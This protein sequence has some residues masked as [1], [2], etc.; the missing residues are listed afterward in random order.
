[1]V[2][3]LNTNRMD[4]TWKEVPRME[5]ISREEFF[6]KFVRQRRPLVIRNLMDSWKALAWTRNYFYSEAPN[7]NLVIKKGNISRGNRETI[8]LGQYIKLLDKYE[9]SLKRGENPEEPP[10]LHDVP[11]FHI[12][13]KLRADIEPFPLQIFPRWYW[14]NWQ[15]YVQFFM[16][17]TG[18]LTPLHFDTLYTNNLFFQVV[19]RKKFFL[20]PAE[21]KRNCYVEGWR[22]AKFNPSKPDFEAYPNA[23]ETTPVELI[24]EPGDVLFIPAGTLHQVHGLSFSI[25]INIDWH[26]PWTAFAGL[27]SIF[28][29]A[30]PKNAYYNLICCLGLG[31]H[32]PSARLFRFYK[33]Y[34]NYLS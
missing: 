23:A 12:L 31:L 18:S 32:I 10:Y 14:E 24:L 16:G 30:P 21:Q 13:P 11:I 6:G 9:S 20:I 5:A 27:M 34:L 33:S 28:Q 17:G 19:G 3:G 2:K 15:N 7:V 26:T 1:M 8:S 25:S 22:W 4:T 29:G